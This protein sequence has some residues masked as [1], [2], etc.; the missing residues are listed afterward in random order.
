VAV[1]TL[2]THLSRDPKVKA[3]FEREVGTI[4]ELQHPNTIQVYDFG[5]TAEG[6]LYIVME[7]LQGLSLAD[8]LE[9]QGAMN[10]DRAGDI[11]QQVCGSLEEA[12]GRGIVHRDLK[13]D[14]VVLVERAGKKDFVK[15][16]DFGIAKRSKEEDKNEQKLT[17]QGMVLG[18]P[19]YMSPEQFTGQPIDLRSDIY[20]L[21]V[22]AYEML[23][24]RLPFRANTAFEWANQH[25]T[26]A[27]IPIESLAEGMRAPEGMRQAI[28]RALAKNPDERFQT[29]SEFGAALAGKGPVGVVPAAASGRAKTEVGTPLDVGAAFGAG[30]PAGG[31][32]P[33]P[34][35]PASG[36]VSYPTPAAI[37][38]PP[39]R[40]GSGGGGGKTP[41]LIAAGVIGVA[42]V[43][44]IALALRSGSGGASKEVVFDNSGSQPAPA[45]SVVPGSAAQDPTPPPSTSSASAGDLPALVGGGAGGGAAPHAVAP[46][47][48]PA[49][50][51]GTPTPG[52]PGKEPPP[53][54]TGAAPAPAPA[55]A[56]AA[57]RYDGPEC[58]KAR[59]L[60]AIGRT[61][62]AQGYILACEAKGGT[63]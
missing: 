12:H 23:T 28:R 10:P 29:M 56:P 57:P 20:S 43:V 4:A 61:K 30:A 22:M 60:K 45:T 3:R 62:E 52:T 17:Q 16:L 50:S 27:P 41:L 37:P 47:P 54:P 15:V 53:A 18:T 34:Y 48:Q 55:P 42:S 9:K 31:M 26:Q 13:P 24:G 2:H 35:T 32:S 38:Q 46:H 1:K 21:G 6:I 63:P 11:L 51:G 40:A 5:S 44:A 36:N 33:A 59:Q 7:F 25:M 8:T 14:N 19:P 58:Q 39:P 49:H